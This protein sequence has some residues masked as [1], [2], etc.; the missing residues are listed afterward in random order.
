MNQAVI[1]DLDGTLYDNKCLHWMLPLCELFSLRLGYLGR[2]RSTRK[3]IRTQNFA[4][5][6]DFYA[7]FF[8]NISKHHPERAGLWYHRHYLPLQAR[9][10]RH[11]CKADPWVK[12]RIQQLR[13]QGIKVVLYSDY[14]YAEQK[15]QA[16]GLDP[17]LFDAIVD[18]PSLGGLKPNEQVT[19]RL[20]AQIGVKPE[21]ALFVGDREDCDAESARRVGSRHQL[22]IRRGKEVSFSN[23]SAS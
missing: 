3:V 8:G 21:D 17:A 2:E 22:V 1:F 5:S 18:A 16:L 7:C 10:L 6:E 11:F 4:S 13:S 23:V 15:L 9:I 12:P 20:L 19:R 14:G